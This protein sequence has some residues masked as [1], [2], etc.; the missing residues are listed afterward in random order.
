MNNID[1][2][3]KNL[4]RRMMA[5]RKDMA[6]GHANPPA[7]IATL[8]AGQ[9]SNSFWRGKKIS[10]YL[11]I[12]S[13]LSPNSLLTMLQN[14]GATICLPAVV[15]PATPLVFRAYNPGDKLQPEP[16]STM[17][18]MA[19]KPEI[20][21]DIMFVPLLA[22]DEKKFRLGYG[23]GFYDRTIAKLLSAVSAAAPLIT[24][25]LAW[26]GQK[27]DNVPVGEFD[28]PLDCILTERK[29]YS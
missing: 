19:D 8:L 23:G 2:D 13:E 11:P 27:I 4:R 21:P 1:D 20:T 12:G 28:K 15:A 17:A 29:F 16:F 5:L 9:F 7:N 3:K 10:F 6:A 22:F 24:I 25:G 26:D 14:L 18:P